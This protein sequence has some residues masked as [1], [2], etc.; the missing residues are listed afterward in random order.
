MDHSTTL[1]L[2]VSVPA[3]TANLGPGYDTLGLALDLRLTATAA[4]SDQWRV[5][6]EGEGHTELP[7]DESNLMIQ[8]YQRLCE[9]KGWDVSPLDLHV[10]NP[11]PLGRG[12]GSSAAAIVAG[13]ALAQLA[14][15]GS[16]SRE[17]LFQH[18]HGMEGHG[19]NV[20]PATFGGLQRI[21]GEGEGIKSQPCALHPAV[22]VLLVIPAQ[23]K[24]TVR[25]R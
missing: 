16:L 22:K 14:H 4:I 20:G 15:G 17:E 21:V 24:S 13:L 6:L 11:I 2:S 3:T 18:A 23:A 9:H 19:D 1:D 10:N 5:Q 7:R 12:L 25:M 8:A